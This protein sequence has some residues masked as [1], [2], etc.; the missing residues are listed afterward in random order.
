MKNKLLVI[1]FLLVG[2]LVGCELNNTPTSKVEEQLSKYQMLDDDVTV[3]YTDLTTDVDIDNEYKER[4]E[5][6]IKKQYRNLSYEVK[7]ETLDG[8]MATVTVE[9]E[10]MDYQKVVEQYDNLMGDEYH[11]QVLTALEEAKD[12]ITYTIEFVVMKDEEGNW[13]LQ[14]LDEVDKRKILGINE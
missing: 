1:G 4:Y 7:E 5:D 12:K 10:V 13:N 3:V 11:V 8:E 6:L 9:V 2:I 14:S